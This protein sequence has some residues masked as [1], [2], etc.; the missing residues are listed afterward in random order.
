[1]E[2]L[3]T[4]A[5]TAP[6]SGGCLVQA[7]MQAGIGG[8]DDRRQGG[9][10]DL[11]PGFRAPG[12]P[13]ATRRCRDRLGLRMESYKFPNKTALQL[14]EDRLPVSLVFGLTGFLLSYLICIPL[15]IAKA[16]R[17]GGAFDLASSLLVFVGY[18]IPPIALGMLLRMLLCGTVDNFWDLFP[19]SGFHSDNFAA[20]SFAQK[21]YDLFMHMFLPV[22]CYMAGDF[23]VLKIG[24]AH[25]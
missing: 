18:A 16:L 21:S 5:E 24:R 19:V 2:G 3:R 22:L 1:M 10:R 23:A 11:G 9:L 15:G 13:G 4:P 25:V 6:A 12:R 7:L 20:M 8:F 17:H 14:I